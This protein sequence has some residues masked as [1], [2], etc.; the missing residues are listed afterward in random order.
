MKRG[1]NHDAKRKCAACSWGGAAHEQAAHENR[2]RLDCH[3][4]L[5]TRPV[6]NCPRLSPRLAA[7]RA[8]SRSA[9]RGRLAVDS[10]RTA[11]RRQ[12]RQ[13]LVR[14]SERVVPDPATDCRSEERYNRRPHRRRSM[15]VTFRPRRE[16]K[17][18][19]TLP[20]TFHETR[21]SESFLDAAGP[22][23]LSG[24]PSGD[25]GRKAVTSSNAGVVCTRDSR[26][27]N[28][29]TACKH[30]RRAVRESSGI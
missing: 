18:V 2:R 10:C 12:C 29:P 26:P 13:R 22:E 24:D 23:L 4:E 5:P 27:A 1:Q 17:F 6:S 30:Y 14:E 28:L 21:T 3:R 7:R 15:P 11:G 16:T 8:S 25:R 19:S 20:G 9:G